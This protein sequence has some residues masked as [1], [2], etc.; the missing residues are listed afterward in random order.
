MT[1]PLV[2]RL[3]RWAYGRTTGLFAALFLMATFLHVRDSRFIT[4]DVPLTLFCTLAL[5]GALLGCCKDTG[6]LRLASLAVGLAAGTKYTGA[7]VIIPVWAAIFMTPGLTMKKRVIRGVQCL[8]IAA[9]VFLLTTP[10]AVLDSDSFLRDLRYQQYTTEA[11]S[12]I[13]GGGGVRW[14]SYL[15]GELRWG[16]GL[17]L[18]VL[19][20]T[21][22]VYAFR[23]RYRADIVLLTFIIPY[24]LF[25]GGWSRHWGRWILP[26]VPPLL[27]LGARYWV[28]E[29]IPRFRQHPFSRPLFALAVCLLL[30]VPLY[31][32]LRGG[33]LLSRTDT[34]TLAYDYLRESFD[35]SSTPTFQTA[36][37]LPLE[38]QNVLSMDEY[39]GGIRPESPSTVIRVYE[40]IILKDRPAFA[41]GVRHEPQIASFESL[42]SA[43][44][45]DE[46][47]LRLFVISS[48]YRDIVYDPRVIQ[49]YPTL[50]S[51][52]RFY[53][54]LKRQTT[55]LAEFS[56]A[57][58][59]K[60]LPFHVENIY[61]PTVYLS[62]MERPGP[63]IEIRLLNEDYFSLSRRQESP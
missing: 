22:V 61:S 39:L 21:G 49:A 36:F 26:I 10:Y 7:L 53:E 31:A 17:P 11:S 19:A 59:G 40:N 43:A 63:R 1:I 28:E 29:L 3:G 38:A 37:S 56:P 54:G 15:T 6:Y 4:V 52:H 16:L 57:R 45:E 24:F 41:S 27:V 42:V 12:P 20:L 25:I 60:E 35:L 58:P 44:R 14:L 8:S 46:E 51:Y 23:K 55:L 50:E 18:E 32:S 62:R 2:F 48:F 5:W 47:P 9:L 33:Y 30:I 34:R 13:Y